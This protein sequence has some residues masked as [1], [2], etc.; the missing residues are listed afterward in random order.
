MVGA[1]RPAGHESLNVVIPW[2]DELFNYTSKHQARPA[3]G[4]LTVGDRT[5]ALGGDTGDAWGV[6]DVGR[7][8]WP[9]EVVWNWGGGAGK[10]ALEGSPRKSVQ[11]APA[12]R[13]WLAGGR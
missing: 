12:R 7:G 3:T 11:K 9:A 6:L 5:W 13:P 10:P 1:R 2:S 4:S 8:R